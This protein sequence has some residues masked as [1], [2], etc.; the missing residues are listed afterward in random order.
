MK[1]I[2]IPPGIKAVFWFPFISTVIITALSLL[3]NYFSYSNPCTFGTFVDSNGLKFV[4]C[5]NFFKFRLLP[6]TVALIRRF[7]I[8][9]LS[10]TF[11]FLAA[12]KEIVSRSS[13]YCGKRHHA[14]QLN[15]PMPFISHPEHFFNFDLAK[16]SSRLEYFKG[17][18]SC[19]MGVIK[20]SGEMYNSAV[21]C[22]IS[23]R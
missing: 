22:I 13:W 1:W 2:L 7:E 16:V 14:F 15:T 9:R 5:Q 19:L 3:A 12:E 21:Y 17:F 10:Y 11:C 8:E 23:K 4:I 6:E 20:N 18:H